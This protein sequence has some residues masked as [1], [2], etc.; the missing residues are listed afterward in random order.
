MQIMSPPAMNTTLKAGFDRGIIE[1]KDN[2]VDLPTELGAKPFPGG[3][4]SFAGKIEKGPEKSTYQARDLRDAM[5]H[6][7]LK[8]DVNAIT[9]AQVDQLA[10]ELGESLKSYL[11]DGDTQEHQDALV[12]I[13]K[14]FNFSDSYNSYAKSNGLLL[15]YRNDISSDTPFS[16]IKKT[17]DEIADSVKYGNN[18]PSNSRVLK[19]QLDTLLEMVERNRSETTKGSLSSGM[20]VELLR[21]QEI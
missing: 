4:D 7:S 1:S 3:E 6:L 5:R 13:L 18:S 12:F 17:I 8:Y 21:I 14:L 20:M 19:N 10:A 11:K 9:P 15:D 2:S 16:L